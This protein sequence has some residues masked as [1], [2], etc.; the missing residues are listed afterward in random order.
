[1]DAIEQ[2]VT[3]GVIT[4]DDR[5]R[6][7]R[8]SRG[9]RFPELRSFH[10]CRSYRCVAGT[11]FAEL[12][13]R[14]ALHGSRVRGDV[15]DATRC[16]NPRGL[17]GFSRRRACNRR[18]GGLERPSK[19]DTG[20]LPSSARSGPSAP[21]EVLR[22]PW[23]L[24]RQGVV[25]EHAQINNH[26]EIGAL[27]RPACRSIQSYATNTGDAPRSQISLDHRGGRKSTEANRGAWWPAA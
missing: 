10:P 14:D 24:V 21:A 6:L 1:M 8:P 19:A 26:T 25:R 7:T 4:A 27:N 22:P 12:V 5:P 17:G 13:G 20:K 3:A 15:D 23:P 9:M 18:L 11:I 16:A 2:T